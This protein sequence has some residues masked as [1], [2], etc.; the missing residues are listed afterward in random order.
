M[1]YIKRVDTILEENRVLK[2]KSAE[3][4]ERIRKQK[5]T[6]PLRIGKR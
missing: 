6:R 1:G 3:L 4:L 2:V 5:Q